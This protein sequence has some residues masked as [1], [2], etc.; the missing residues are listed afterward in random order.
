MS[1]NRS[2]AN[3][4]IYNVEESNARSDSQHERQQRDQSKTDGIWGRLWLERLLQ[5][6]RYALHGFSGI[7]Q[8]QAAHSLSFSFQTI[9]IH[10]GAS[11]TC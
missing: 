3:N 8:R 7:P 2:A 5:D 11:R 6:V 9:L 1:P 4:A 10:I